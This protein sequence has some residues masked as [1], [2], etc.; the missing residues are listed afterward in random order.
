MA[1]MPTR[2]NYG[3]RLT[4]QQRAWQLFTVLLTL[5]IALALVNIAVW[6]LW[7][8][9]STRDSNSSAPAAEIPDVPSFDGSS[10]QLIQ[11]IVVPTLE[12]QVPIGK[13]AVWCA[14]G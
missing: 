5:D 11:S 3:Q 4:V 6:D 10:E 7:P 8:H 1:N 9:L 13:S 14:T 2:E 12:S